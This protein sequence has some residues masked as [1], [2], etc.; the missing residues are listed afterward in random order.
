MRAR[1]GLAILAFAGAACGPPADPAA[2]AAGAFSAS[3]V[4]FEARPASWFEHLTDGARV[5]PDGRSLIYG[6]GKR[7]L[8]MRL[9]DGRASVLPAP[10]APA[11]RTVFGPGGVVRMQQ[12]DGVTA[13]R[14]DGSET[15][16]HLPSDVVPAWTSDGRRLATFNSAPPAAELTVD[17]V[18]HAVAGHLLSVEWM[19]DGQRLVTLS[20]AADDTV[21]LG[22]L[23]PATST[24]RVVARD[25]DGDV[26]PAQFAVTPDGAGAVLALVSGQAA[27]PRSRHDPAADRDLDLWRVDLATGQ[28]TPVV[29]TPGDDFSPSFADGHLYYVHAEVTP[30]VVVVPIAGGDARAVVSPGEL[31]YWRPDGRQLA[32]TVGGWRLRDVALPLDV[33]VVDMDANASPF[34]QP[35][36]F[37]TGFH[38]DFSP[39]WSPDGRWLAFHSHRSPT[40]VTSYF[41]S[42]STDDIWL[43][44][45]DAPADTERRL[46]DFGHEAGMADWAPDGRR[47]AFVSHPAPGLSSLRTYIVSIDSDSGRS[48]GTSV[49]PLPDGVL[50]TETVAWSPDGQKLAVESKT[51]GPNHA[52]WLLDLA[53]GTGRALLQYPSPTFGGVDF[54]PDGRSVVFGALV[55]DSMQ[56]RAFDLESS[57][58][59]TLTRAAD[60]AFL[61]QVSPDGRWVAATSMR[62]QRQVRRQPWP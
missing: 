62:H 11:S 25:L 32:F 31:P 45:A 39:A 41:G 55:G 18:T 1:S 46:T 60:G 29:Q 53:R 36:P 23:D 33:H 14:Q 54:T 35:R 50:S 12:R 27:D 3:E 47:L 40:P 51:A 24:F 9:D 38:E 8:V 13:W 10:S 61:P 43:A 17:G 48:T 58:V 37:I 57:A 2:V 4:V 22:S 28:R 34:G 16:V 5:A 19:P 49:L 26:Y 30:S 42:G 7:A 44:R 59:R 56:V 21:T 20:R 52:L 6:S 15:R